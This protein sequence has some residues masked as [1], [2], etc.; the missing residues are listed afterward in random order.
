MGD[1]LFFPSGLLGL[2]A[3]VMS[4]ILTLI[5]PRETG[6][7]PDGF[8]TPVVAF[9]FAES[10]AEV[11]T[12]FEPEGSAAAMDRLNRWDFLFMALYSLFLTTF[13]LAAAL[14]SGRFTLWFAAALAPLILLADV[15]ENVQLLNLT[16]QLSLGGGMESAL[17]RLHLFTWLKWGGLAVYFLLIGNYFREQ[18]GIWRFVWVL[19]GAPAI[20]ALWAFLRRGPTHELMALSIG[21][22]FLVLTL[23]AWR[24]TLT[25]GPQAYGV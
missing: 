24:Q 2:G 17:D 21:I 18:S 10:A 6:P 20:L 9:E 13:A 5:G 1:R 19:A 8:I 11:A 3:V 16:T 15:M 12:L 25:R 22:L 23:F 4:L 14:D 7:L